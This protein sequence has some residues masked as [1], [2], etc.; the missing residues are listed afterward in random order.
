MPVMYIE[1]SIYTLSLVI[2]ITNLYF[3]GKTMHLMYESCSLVL[4]V[5]RLYMN[6]SAKRDLTH[7]SNSN[8][9]L[10]VKCM[11]AWL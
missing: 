10:A 4:H 6:R 7:I 3:R 11:H 8:V 2:F 9:R 1:C 5:G